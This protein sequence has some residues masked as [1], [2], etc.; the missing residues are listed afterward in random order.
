MLGC[1]GVVLDRR[2]G[3]SFFMEEFLS[4]ELI[5]EMIYED[6]GRNSDL[7]RRNSMC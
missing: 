1:N 7:G 3:R 4:R 5:K 6:I 2:V